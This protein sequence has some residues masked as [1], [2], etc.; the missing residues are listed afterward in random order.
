MDVRR[1]IFPILLG[2]IGTGI[3]CA[4]GT[5]QVNRLAWKEGVLADIE[6][7]ISAPDVA[8]PA[9]L[10]PANDRYL[11]VSAAGTLVGPELHV[12]VSTKK[13]GPGFRVIQ[14]LETADG[15]AILADLGFIPEADKEQ[16]REATSA[17]ISGNLLWP[18]ETDFFTP[19]P[20]RERNIWFAR[21]A[22][23]MAREL[24]TEP[25]MLVAR[26][27]EPALAP[28]P[29]PVSLNIPNDHLEYAITWF[30]LAAI[31]IGMTVSWLWRIKRSDL[32]STP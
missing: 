13:D 24:G 11:P 26:T 27:A 30:S 25:V 2:L 15:R 23:T 6:A 14:K 21:N 22:E 5:W 7:R 12:L 28:T 20:N 32:S 18:N 31:W 29:W 3:L 10:N 17:T 19:E 1:Y 4:L 8:L 16:P 9:V